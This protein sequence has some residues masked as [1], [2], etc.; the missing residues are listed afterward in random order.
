ME[1]KN[2]IGID[3]SKESFDL[4]L[5]RDH[6]AEDPVSAKFSNN[7]KGITKLQEFIAKYKLNSCETLFCME[8][9]GI[10]C[11]LLSFY[12]AENNYCVWVEMPVNIIRS[13]GLQRGK[14]DHVDAARIAV[15]ACRN[16]DK[17]NLWQPPREIILDIK[18]LLALRDRLIESRNKLQ[19]PIKELEATGHLQTAKM[20]EDSCKE[21]LSA[22]NK[23]IQ[24]I[25]DDLD[26]KIKSDKRLLKLF[27]LVTSVVGVGKITALLLIYYTN[28]FSLFQNAK[29]LACYCGVAPFE[30]SSGTSVRGKPRVSHYANKQLKKLLHMG[31]L[32][33]I[34]TNEEISNYFQRKVSQGKNKMLVINAI[35]NKLLQ[36]VCAVIRRGTPFVS[37]W[38]LA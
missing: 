32:S 15:Y 5:I 16:K 25:D 17:A 2:F 31:A 24:Q 11:R 30:H 18:D 4:A 37:Q 22:L 9:T 1:Y 10:Y 28:E 27:E 21:S 26:K 29:Q 12:L 7:V 20:I 8:H 19:Q 13:L 35:R 14:S 38:E 23:E 34:Q 3:I 6:Q 33:A 36:R